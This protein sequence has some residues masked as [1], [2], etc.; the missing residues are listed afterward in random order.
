MKLQRITG[1]L[2][3]AAILVERWRFQRWLTITVTVAA[4][5]TGGD[6]ATE[7]FSEVRTRMAA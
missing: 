7:S 1:G 4:R 5:T 2:A 6:T 3:A